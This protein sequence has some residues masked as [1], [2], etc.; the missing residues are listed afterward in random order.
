MRL[1]IRLLGI[2]RQRILVLGMVVRT[3][4]IKM[5]AREEMSR[6]AAAVVG[7]NSGFSVIESEEAVFN[8]ALRLRIS[9]VA[10]PQ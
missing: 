4:R 8:P 7:F 2:T 1:T 6:S 9:D 5:N 10:V 3:C